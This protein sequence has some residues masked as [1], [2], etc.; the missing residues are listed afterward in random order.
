LLRKLFVTLNKLQI[1]GKKLAPMLPPTTAKTAV[2][3]FFVKEIPP[4]IRSNF[5]G[6]ASH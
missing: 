1:S 2:M 5:K 3:I 6:N 4:S